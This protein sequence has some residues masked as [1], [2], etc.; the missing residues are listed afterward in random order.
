MSLDT[1]GMEQLTSVDFFSQSDEL[2]FDRLKMTGGF[3]RNINQ[4]N[5]AQNILIAKYLEQ[6]VSFSLAI[7]YFVEWLHKT[8]YY[9]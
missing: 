7:N 8:S 4:L 6:I 1:E 2:L 5:K 3:L 9:D